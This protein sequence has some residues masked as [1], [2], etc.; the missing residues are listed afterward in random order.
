MPELQCEIP[1]CTHPTYKVF[2]RHMSKYHPSIANPESPV[3]KKIQS[4]TGDSKHE[5]VDVDEAMK[6]SKD[7]AS[8]GIIPS[9]TKQGKKPGKMLGIGAFFKTIAKWLNATICKD[10]EIIMDDATAKELEQ[11]FN[12]AFGIYI[13]PLVAFAGSIFM[14]FIIPILLNL[15]GEEIITKLI[16]KFKDGIF[17]KLN[18]GDDTDSD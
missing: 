14:I 11:Q 17:N 18:S 10:P 3:T 15:F 16:L 13:E 2:S 7:K 5:W 12:D 6:K 1:N 4:P 8:K 9:K